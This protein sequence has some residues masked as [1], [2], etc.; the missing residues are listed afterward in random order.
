MGQGVDLTDIEDQDLAANI[1]IASGLVNTHCNV[2]VDHDFRG[3]TVTDE[4]HRWKMGNYMW[5]GPRRV[6]PNHYP[7]TQ[8]TSFKIY[9]TNTQ[10]LDIPVAQVNWEEFSNALEPVIAAESIGVWTASAIPIA[11][12]RE[13]HARISYSYGFTFSVTDEQM[14]PEGGIRWRGQNQWW[15]STVTP[16]IK[17]N[18]ITLDPADVTFDYDEGTVDIDD[19]V[20]TALDID[21]TEVDHVRATYTHKL[22]SNVMNA[23]AMITT[24]LLGRRSIAERGMLGLSGITVNEVELRQ[25]RDSQIAVDE[26]P[27]NA[28][29]LL[30]PYRRF[31]WGA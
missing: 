4:E 22:P 11:G 15:D 24:S 30:V 27:G 26:I 29:M 14:F 8:L 6:F 31:H 9:V 7:L 17:V 25:S 16:V 19:D 12:F 20:L 13:P 18:G 10:Y 1:S 23:T 21:V 28:R 3:G 2:E 5:P